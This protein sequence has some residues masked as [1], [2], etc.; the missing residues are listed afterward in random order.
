[1]WQYCYNKIFVQVGYKYWY[2]IVVGL[3]IISKNFH[4]KN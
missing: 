4:D 2:N 3:F 1:M